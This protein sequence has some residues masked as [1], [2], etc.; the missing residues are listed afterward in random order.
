MDLEEFLLENSVTSH[1]E[2][3]EEQ[4]Q[5]Q[6]VKHLHSLSPQQQYQVNLEHRPHQNGYN[7]SNQLATNVLQMM[8]SPDNNSSN[9]NSFLN[10]PGLSITPPDD[11]HDVTMKSMDVMGRRTISMSEEVGDSLLV[12]GLMERRSH[13]LS[14]NEHL[15]SSIADPQTFVALSP[16]PSNA[17]SCGS[18]TLSSVA[19]SNTRPSR[20]S[21]VSPATR[22]VKKEP[23]PD[24]NKDEKYWKRREK[25]NLAAKRS[26][27]LRREKE[28]A[29]MER[30]QYLEREN[31]SLSQS[32]SDFK[33]ENQE[34]KERLAR[35]ESL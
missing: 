34:L 32:L 1:Q 29:I 33:L 15:M 12:N 18:T 31:Q 20:K 9:N 23:V 14:E 11:V 24:N 35:Y 4:Q 8:A 10:R 22:R 26:R 2:L 30:V 5:Q 21:K 27:D 17:S 3:K 25:N 16:S 19:T 28:S 6:D 7:N 13:S